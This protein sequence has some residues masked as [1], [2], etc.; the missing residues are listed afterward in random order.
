MFSIRRFLLVTLTLIV[1][2]AGTVTAL[3]VYRFA[4]HEVEEL[5]DA[6]LVQHGRLLA[7]W[8]EESGAE[9]NLTAQVLPATGH[10]YE[11]Y[12][13]VQ[14]V[15]P[16]GALFFSTPLSLDQVLAP[17]QPGISVQTAS[18]RRWH[19]FA[20]PLQDG[21]WLMVAEE[22]HVRDELSGE[23]MVAIIAPLLLTWPLLML[24]VI[25]ALQRGL[26]PLTK[27]EEA[28]RGRH[29]KHLAA[30]EY[31]S[32]IRELALLVAEL[33]RLF[34]RIDEVLA[35]E[36]RFT[37]DAAHELRTL[38][39]VLK[40]HAGNAREA[41]SADE[42]QHALTQLLAGIGRAERTVLQLLSLARLEADVA[43]RGEPVLLLPALRQV[44][45]DMMPLAEQGHQQLLLDAEDIDQF[46]VG[47]SAELLDMLLRNLIDNAC[48]YSPPGSE[49]AV[50][51]HADGETVEVRVE[52][53]G[54]GLA[55]ELR[56][57]AGE[58]FLRGDH[59]VPGT[60]LGLSI[61]R[62]ILAVCGGSMDFQ[63]RR[64]QQPA[65]VVLRLPVVGQGSAIV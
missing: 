15:S 20:Q 22:E 11:R 56:E 1:L 38:L 36:K 41:G 32:D 26:R 9:S 30:L 42:Q 43:L 29:E 45:A 54:S 60:G 18:G 5:F 12:V 37:D 8:L 17:L 50:R 62:R 47:L 3:A 13:A 16:E 31:G 33:N 27:L 48:R 6:Q 39:S 59:A 61:V 44:L 58:R 40:L 65:T 14:H 10:R 63:P 49:I 35:R 34:V 51:V 46:R 2:A 21:S 7:G 19:V 4:W 25:W 55:E 53:G 57:R 28:L 24:A 23:A 52:D 64:D